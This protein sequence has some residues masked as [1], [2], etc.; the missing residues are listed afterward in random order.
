MRPTD[1]IK[2]KIKNMDFKASNELKQKMLEDVLNEQNKKQHSTQTPQSVWRIIM[3]SNITKLATAAIVIAA[4]LVG[5]NRFGGS[6]DGSSV[7]W[8][9]VVEQI[10]NYTKYKYRERVVRENGPKR[11]IMDVYHLN[12]S[13]RR[14][15]VEN[16]DIH[17][18]DMRGTD[19]ITVELK[20][21]QM[22]A[23]VTKFIGTGPRKDPHIIEMVKR[24]E[25]KTTERLGTKE[26]DGKILQGF[27]HA[28]NARNDFTVWVDPKTKL[29][30]EIELVHT[31]AG[32]TIFMDEF[33]F[34]FDLGPEAFG[35]EIPA[36][37][38]I[39]TLI[40][41]YRPVKPKEITAEDLA[42][43]LKHTAY[44]ID[45][46]SWITNQTIMRVASPLGTRTISYITGIQTDDGNTILIVQ[47]DYYDMERMVWIPNQQ[48]VLE[49]PNGAKLYTHPNGSIYAQRFLDSFAKAKPDLFNAADISD[50]RITRMI[51]MP[52]GTV[53]G[54]VANKQISNDR[55]QALVESL[56]E[57]NT[58]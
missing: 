51:V 42:E 8:A 21:D 26:V 41:D 50:Q 14:Q 43:E 18:I 4:I 56:V 47:G 45:R 49:T 11:P 22:K 40:Q 30:V 7:A 1:N 55:I 24:F 48:L 10:N 53:L 44:T 13:Q 34:D 32:Q 3:K 33:E 20:P 28:P 46:L 27:R 38:E 57:I 37:Y 19:A 17:I 25:Q 54:L 31:K 16:G 5:I 29:P 23:T 9:Q 15:E 35:T 39:E 52:N 12:L 6:I 36:G 58:K 2:N